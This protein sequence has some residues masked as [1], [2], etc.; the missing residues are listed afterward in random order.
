MA[1]RETIVPRLP[2]ELSELRE[3]LVGA[4]LGLATGVPSP[5]EIE[6]STVGILELDVISWGFSQP[7][8]LS[9][10]QVVPIDGFVVW[11]AS[12]SNVDPSDGG[13]KLSASS[14]RF[15]MLWPSGEERSYAVAVYRNVYQGEEL[16]PKQQHQT[17]FG[18]A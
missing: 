5:I 3:Y 18:A 12:G 14:R 15:S 9:A 6:Q 8:N 7:K 11:W 10:Y 16:G 2:K 17:W 4:D 1:I 13:V